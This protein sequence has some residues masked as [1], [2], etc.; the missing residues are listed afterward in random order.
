VD[1]SPSSLCSC[2]H[3]VFT[4][5]S[6][7]HRF[8]GWSGGCVTVSGVTGWMYSVSVLGMV[9]WMCHCLWGGR[10]DVSPFGG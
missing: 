8:W 6:G 1:V 3:F 9:G 4:D 2:A 5:T 10:V 7:N